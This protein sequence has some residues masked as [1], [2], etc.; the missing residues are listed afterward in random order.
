LVASAVR[1]AGE[2]EAREW[3]HAGDPSP[4][5]RLIA[6]EGDPATLTTVGR[7]L[8]RTL[9]GPNLAPTNPL[10]EATLDDAPARPLV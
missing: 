10:L 1:A 2:Q 3:F 4:L 8:R 7:E 5:A 9:T 6:A